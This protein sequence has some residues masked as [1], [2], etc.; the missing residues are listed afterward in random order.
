VVPGIA[1]R[2]SGLVASSFYLPSPLA[3]QGKK[4]IFT[5]LGLVGFF[6]LCFMCMAV[7]LVRV[8]IPAQTA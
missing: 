6:F 1:L 5:I 7:V 8:S 3:A 4:H 2:A